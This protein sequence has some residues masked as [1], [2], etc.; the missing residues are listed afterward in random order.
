MT[1]HTVASDLLVGFDIQLACYFKE[2]ADFLKIEA[3]VKYT[4]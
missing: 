4:I 2:C 3:I 1:S